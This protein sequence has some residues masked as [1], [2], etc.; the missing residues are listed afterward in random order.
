MKA[1]EAGPDQESDTLIKEVP[2]SPSDE[3]AV[4]LPKAERSQSA[5]QQPVNDADLQVT[6]VAVPDSS[7]KEAVQEQGQEV[8]ELVNNMAIPP[9]ERSTDT[10]ENNFLCNE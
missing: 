1:S 8:E 9:G 4:E 5:E 2:V 7:D 6:E 10:T 3:V